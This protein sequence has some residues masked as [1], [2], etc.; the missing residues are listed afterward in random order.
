MS[1]D[2]LLSLIRGDF[3]GHVPASEISP[4]IGCKMSKQSTLP[5][6]SMTSLSKYPFELVYFDVWGNPHVPVPTRIGNRYHV[7]FLRNDSRYTWVYFMHH[8]S[9]LFSIYYDFTSMIRTQFGDHQAL[10]L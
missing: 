9:T 3:L 5:L 4:Y 6:S 1:L 2:H 8:R 10:S 7:I